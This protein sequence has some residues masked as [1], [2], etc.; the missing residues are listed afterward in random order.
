MAEAGATPNAVNPAFNT[1]F[2]PKTED[3]TSDDEEE[4]SGNGMAATTDVVLANP[5][6]AT[7]SVQGTS[8][9]STA[10]TEE[11]TTLSL[12]AAVALTGVSLSVDRPRGYSTQVRNGRARGEPSGL[13]FATAICCSTQYSDSFQR[14]PGSWMCFCVVH[15]ISILI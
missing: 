10:T 13:S 3:D 4:E 15:M 9:P 2:V 11:S 5:V 6:S 8:L 1:E 7:A 12:S 14:D